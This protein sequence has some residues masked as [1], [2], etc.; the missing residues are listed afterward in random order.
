M[1]ALG[2]IAPDVV[3]ERRP[4]PTAIG[5]MLVLGVWFFASYG[6]ANWTASQRSHVPSMAFSWERKI[7]FFA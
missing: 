2:I 1:V 6:F 7:P 4:W 5:Y 3:K